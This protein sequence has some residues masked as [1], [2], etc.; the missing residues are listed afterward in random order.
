MGLFD[1]QTTNDQAFAS[2]KCR[3]AEIDLGLEGGHRGRA[4]RARRGLLRRAYEGFGGSPVGVTWIM[5]LASSAWAKL[6]AE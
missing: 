6:A 2:L 4:R 1:V 5:P 3:L